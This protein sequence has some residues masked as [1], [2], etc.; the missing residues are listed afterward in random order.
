MKMR[1][2]LAGVRSVIGEN[3]VAAIMEPVPGG[4]ARC[5]GQR[6]RRDVPIAAT[7]FAQSREVL[8][9][10]DE[11]VHGRL[12]VQVAE[13]H[14]VL[15]LSDEFRTK[16]AACDATEN[17]IGIGRVRHLFRHSERLGNRTVVRSESHQL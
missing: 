10:H 12:G 15:A 5:K 13:G 8:A 2:S 4:D 6:V 14:V 7:D 1:N 9:R 3:P 16:L 17:A 11:H